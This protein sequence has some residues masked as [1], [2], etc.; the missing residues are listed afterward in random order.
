MLYHFKKSC[1][2]T[3]K[4]KQLHLREINPYHLVF[5]LQLHTLLKINKSLGICAAFPRRECVN[6]YSA[7]SHKIDSWM[8]ASLLTD[9][10][11]AYPTFHFFVRHYLSFLKWNG[12]LLRNRR[13]VLCIWTLDI[14]IYS[15][16]NKLEK[17]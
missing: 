9:F 2:T 17:K 8:Y 1:P 10:L 7:W 11:T 3:T 13:H 4:K 6:S 16:Q 12:K 14:L 15:V 5:T